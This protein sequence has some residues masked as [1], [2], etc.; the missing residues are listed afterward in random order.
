MPRML[1]NIVRNVFLSP[2][3]RKYPFVVREPFVGSRGKIVFKAENCTCCGTCARRC[4]AA[5]ICEACVEACPKKD[6]VLDFKWRAPYYQKPVE[7]YNCPAKEA[8][9]KEEA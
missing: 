2:A 9:G 3:T 6:I 8:K 7:V 4:P 5:A 1:P